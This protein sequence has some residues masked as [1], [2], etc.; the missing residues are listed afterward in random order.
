[1]DKKYEMPEA[2][3]INF[4]IEEIITDSGDMDEET[5]L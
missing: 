2:I 4:T 5:E 3:I 1:M